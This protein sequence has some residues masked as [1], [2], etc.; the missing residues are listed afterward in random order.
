MFDTS[1]LVDL[2]MAGVQEDDILEE[3]RQ[4]LQTAK[5]WAFDYYEPL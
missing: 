1:T 2:W 3:C 4:R 5:A